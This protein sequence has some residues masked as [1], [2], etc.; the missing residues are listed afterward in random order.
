MRQQDFGCC[1]LVVT[2]VLSS[3]IY[4]MDVFSYVF[5]KWKQESDQQKINADDDLPTAMELSK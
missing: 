3:I 1:L 5:T 4:L 2:V